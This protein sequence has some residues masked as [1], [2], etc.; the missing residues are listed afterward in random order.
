MH[1]NQTELP[2]NFWGE[3]PPD[4]QDVLTQPHFSTFELF[5]RRLDHDMKTYNIL[6]CLHLEK[7]LRSE[8]GDL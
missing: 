5:P 2:K 7:L 1:Q 3:K 4:L 6:C 8:L